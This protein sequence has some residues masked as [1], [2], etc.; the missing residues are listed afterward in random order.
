M[1][2]ILLLLFSCSLLQVH[3]QNWLQLNDYPAIGVDDGCSFVI[4][5]KAY[6]GSG[7]DSWFTVRGDFY[8][9]DFTSEQWS[10]I[11]PLPQG[12]NRQ[13]ANGFA[14]DSFGYVFG[15]INGA[16]L[17]DL[18]RYN[19]RSDQW[20]EMSPLPDSGRGGAAV[21]VVDSMA[22]IV[23]GKTDSLSA[24]NTVWAYNMNADRWQRKN[25]FPFGARWRSSA[26]SN[27]SLA[28]LAFGK[29]DNLFY[30]SE[31]FEY[32]PQSD[33]WT[34]LSDFPQGGRNY[35]KMHWLKG[36]L[37]AVAGDDSSG[38]FYNQL[39]SYNQQSSSWKELS[40]LP[41]VGRRGGMSFSSNQAFYYTSGLTKND[42]RITETWKYAISTSLAKQNWKPK[43]RLYPNP[44]KSLVS[45]DHP[46]LNSIEN[47]QYELA[48]NTG[49]VIKQENMDGKSTQVN[50]EGL[51]RG[52]YLLIIKSEQGSLVRKVVKH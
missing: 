47:W 37:F 36:N 16:F 4:D 52:V 27:D 23:G 20:V 17:N 33:S 9:F 41:A 29:D 6:C 42:G 40:P 34:K 30:R 50:M 38:T 31:L 32:H 15:G 48:D 21:F 26:S 24:I 22:Y 44:T 19:P 39:W 13:Y 10:N 51:Q 25:N 14:S 12:K 49:R 2:K 1:H 7:V 43:L 28:Y 18:W 45:I 35:V 46:S 3:A 11:A 8:S 5:N